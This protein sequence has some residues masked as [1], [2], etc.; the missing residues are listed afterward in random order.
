MTELI[1]HVGN[2]MYIYIMKK[3][4]TCEIIKPLSEFGK[5]KSWHQSYCKECKSIMDKTDR[6][7]NPEKYRDRNKKKWAA[8]TQEQK[9]K[10]NKAKKHSIHICIDCNVEIR[11]RNDTL[12]NWSGRCKLCT[13]KEIAKRPEIILKKSISAREQVLKQGGIPN[14]HHFTSDHSGENH[15]NWQGGITP[16]RVAEWNGKQYQEWRNTVLKRDGYKCVACGI[17][18]H[19]LEVDHIK[20]YSLYPDL[21]YKIDNGRTLCKPCHKKYG[22]WANRGKEYKPASFEY[23][24]A[25]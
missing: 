4:K 9:D 12:K 24:E 19:K 1:G 22:T 8:F 21:R 15:Y 23:L 18:D 16:I 5:C 13:V 6:L 3:C 10:Q 2:Y 11:K 17:N 25:N 7:L 20:S 14:A